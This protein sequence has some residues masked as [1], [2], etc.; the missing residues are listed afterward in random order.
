MDT[1]YQGLEEKGYLVL[2]LHGHQ[3]FVHHPDIEYPIEEEWLYE[4]QTDC[5]LPLIHVCQELLNEGIRSKLTFSLS[6]TLCMMLS[7]GYRQSRYIR[8]LDERITFLESKVK[9]KG[10]IGLDDDLG[11]W[12]CKRFAKCCRAMEDE[13]GGNIIANFRRLQEQQA[14]SIIASAATH[15]YLPLWELY[16]DIVNLQ[17]EL[18]IQQYIRDFGNKPTGFW[19]PECGYFKGLDK[20]LR[21]QQINYF[22]LSQHGVLNGDPVPT[23]GEF[24][25]VQTPNG[26]MAFARDVFID[27]QVCFK[28]IG[29]PGDPLYADFHSDIGLIWPS[30]SVRELTHND[31][32]ATTGIR[33]YRDGS[34]ALQE[35][36][37]PETA[38]IRCELH[39]A[40]FVDQCQRRVAM[41]NETLGRKPIITG[42]FDMEHFGHWWLEGPSWLKHVI[43]KLSCESSTVKIITADEYLTLC[44]ESEIVR[45][46]MSSWGYQG[47]SETWLMGRNDWIY[48][49]VF[50]AINAF[51][52]L[53]ANDEQPNGLRQVA[54]NQYL[55]EL[56][57][58][59]SSD[60]AF[61]MHAQTAAEYATQRVKGH[62]A[63]MSRIQFGLEENSL[64]PYW[65]ASL[66]QKNNIFA[67]IDLLEHYRKCDSTTK[68]EK[69]TYVP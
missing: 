18:G 24:A 13:S 50:K 43:R 48:P 8:H 30:E 40:H 49:A 17:I 57:L 35:R 61:I 33:C 10:D 23:Y 27:H 54:L 52:E 64:D 36:Y 69:K 15:A 66:Q 14:I 46:S 39:A 51:R 11:F 7:D 6:P 4:T 32:P 41:L 62:L 20:F 3:P 58:A 2:V 63:N 29:Y 55:R 28:K 19:L 34:V 31:G 26:V 12:Y 9:L 47:Y 56:L 45:P 25:T 22:F 5:Y 42:L 38:E 59:Q 53:M 21:H 37:N 68:K 16:P 1:V 65:L 60:W 67:D 44:P